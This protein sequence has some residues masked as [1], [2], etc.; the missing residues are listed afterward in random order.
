MSKFLVDTNIVIHY[1][2]GEF[3]LDKRFR[4]AGLNNIMISEISIA[5]LRY[6][7]A[8]S[9]KK[10]ENQLVVDGLIEQFTI[11]PIWSCLTLY[12]MEKARLRNTGIVIDEFDLLIGCSAILNNL[13]M[14]TR[15]EKHFNKLKGIQLENW[16]DN[17]LGR[18]V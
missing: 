7:A 9:T 3:E 10:N 8:N 12:G 4:K 2:K 15:N 6:G 16:I 17:Y 18:S 14:V 1:L 11:L 5:E 13:V